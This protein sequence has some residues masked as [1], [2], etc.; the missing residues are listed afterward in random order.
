MRDIAEKAG[1]SIATVSLAMHNHPSIS[2]ATRRGIQK[3][4]EQMGYRPHP[5]VSVLMHQVRASHLSSAPSPLALV[6]PFSSKDSWRTYLAPELITGA[7]TCAERHGFRLEEFWMGDL[8]MTGQQLSRVL[9]QR[10]ITGLII[11]P[12]PFA[13]SQLSLDWSRFS[14]VAI[15]QS[16][17]RPELNR[18]S[19]NRF[20]AMRVAA[21]QLR[22]L[23]YERLGLAMDADQD[24]RGVGH[25]WTAAF[26][27]EQRH[28]SPKHKTL[29]LL[30]KE[31]RWVE[32]V[33]DRWF[34]AERPQ[35]VLGSDPST[36]AWL[37]N[38]GQ[39]V[40][41]DVG[42][43]HLWVPDQSGQFAGIYHNPP[44]LGKAAMNLLIRMIED[45]ERGLPETPQTLLLNA[46]WVDGA[47]VTPLKSVSNRKRVRWGAANR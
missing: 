32:P 3:L 35:V 27:W 19:I 17:A 28:S 47:T 25:E 21:G 18:V 37:R 40:P 39:R 42:F 4:A 11:A 45:N 22:S 13:N 44:A 24:S 43:V 20:Q 36:V 34:N 5:L 1:V 31:G 2:V 38:L 41:E 7:A 33:F 16:L 46:A 6:I 14:S 23:G 30:P 26:E 12:L 29:M 8:G 9:Y 15:G 10:G